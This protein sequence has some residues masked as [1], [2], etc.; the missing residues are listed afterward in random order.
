MAAYAPSDLDLFTRFVCFG[1]EDGSYNVLAQPEFTDRAPSLGSFLCKEKGAEAISRIRKVFLNKSYITKDPL[2]YAL[3]TIIRKT[4]V[5]DKHEEDEVRTTA[6]ALA[7]EICVSPMDLFTFVHYDKAVADNKK[8]GWGRGMRRLVTKWYES[9]A[10][11]KLASE[12]TKCKS[13]RGWT[14]RD[15]IRQTHIKADKVSK[16]TS[17][18]IKY[19]IQHSKQIENPEDDLE[20]VVTF[21]NDLNSLTSSNSSEGALVRSLIEKHKLVD[22]QIPSFLLQ[23]PETYEGLLGHIKLED[24]IRSIPKMASLRMLDYAAPQ[25]AQ[26]VDVVKNVDR[27]LQ[28][29]IHPMVIFR[30]LRRYES[31]RTKKWVK[32]IHLIK[33]LQAAMIT[34]M[35]NLETIGKRTLLAVHIDSKIAK[36]H[37][38]GSSYL[39][40][41]M[42]CTLMTKFLLESE[43]K[44]HVIFFQ[45]KVFEIPFT[46]RVSMTGIV[47]KF[48]DATKEGMQ[49]TIYLSP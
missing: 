41:I 46:R 6:Y 1:S 40:P 42:P 3:A 31:D 20:P 17:L 5:T 8:A 34:S 44:L 11:L 37:V 28:E 13:G 29:K 12:V 30:S 26:V 45:Q 39:S 22:R 4:P 19:L 48:L 9:K 32:N 7:E 18:V 43:E 35:Q 27:I 25:T 33:A 16:G 47:E 10:P 21:L 2:L 38:I 49:H 36:Q 14:H 15:L 24:V 23:M